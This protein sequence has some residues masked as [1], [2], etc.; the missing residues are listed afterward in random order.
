MQVLTYNAANKLIY[1]YS[2]TIANL[3]T[4]LTTYNVHFTL[5]YKAIINYPESK[6][7]KKQPINLF[8]LTLAN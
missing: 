7:V 8:E 4:H 5:L 6:Q 1:L 3:L 2:Q